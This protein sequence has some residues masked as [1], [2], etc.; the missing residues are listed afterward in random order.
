LKA[1]RDAGFEAVASWDA[2]RGLGGEVRFKCARGKIPRRKSKRPT[3]STSKT[4]S[5]K[6]KRSSNLVKVFIVLKALLQAQKEIMELDYQRSQRSQQL[7]Q[8][9]NVAEEY[10]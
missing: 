8:D 2:R 4:R 5:T 10:E 6:T 3:D 9:A 1:C 7:R